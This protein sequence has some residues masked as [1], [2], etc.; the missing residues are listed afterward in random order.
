LRRLSINFSLVLRR[1]WLP[2]LVCAA[3]GLALAL[4]ALM[5]GQRMAD[6]LRDNALQ[7]AEPFAQLLAD[8]ALEPEYF[9]AGEL[10]PAG[11]VAL[12]EVAESSALAGLR[13]W[14]EDGKLFDSLDPGSSEGEPGASVFAAL[15]GETTSELEEEEDL[16]EAYVPARTTPTGPI[17]HALEVYL[18]YAP[19]EAL[20]AGE[21]E[22]LNLVIAVATIVLWLALLP[23]LLRASRRLAQAPGRD[24]RLERELR[25][26]M[27]EGQIE[28]YYQPLVDLEADR[29]IGAEALI[30]WRHPKQGLLLPG[31][32]LPRVCESEPSMRELTTA[33]LDD[34]LGRIRGW[35]T[36]GLPSVSVNVPAL[37]LFATGFESEVKRL[38]A[39]H[40]T[41]G[42]WLTLEL[43]EDGILDQHPLAADR[44]A[45]L[46][47]LGV[48]ISLDDFGTGHSSLARLARLGVTELKVDRSFLSG[49]RGG[50]P[51]VAIFKTVCG[52]GRTLDLRVVAEGIE[53]PEDLVRVLGLGCTIGQGFLLARPMPAPNLA[54]WLAAQAPPPPAPAERSAVTS[55]SL[56]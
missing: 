36:A 19:V 16:I 56:L 14:N 37:C 17:T 7:Q 52:L 53:L 10:T 9:E 49:M 45:G 5:I 26:A 23:L 48:Q 27:R 55:G 51:D 18:P 25:E 33:V 41:P 35:R 47:R 34:A 12:R 11:E 1:S 29:A 4:L 3:T 46:R 13:L 22:R 43:T 32:F 54:V 38:L 15:D 44:I 6:G 20:I 42:S 2:V 31:E 28:V 39:K 21:R 24:W 50:G 8:S 30:R 40:N